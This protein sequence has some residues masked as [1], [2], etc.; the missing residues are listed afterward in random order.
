MPKGWTLVLIFIH[1]FP[2]WRP[3][4]IFCKLFS[5]LMCIYVSRN[6]LHGKFQSRTP[7]KLTVALLYCFRSFPKCVDSP[8]WDNHKCSGNVG[9]LEVVARNYSGCVLMNIPCTKNQ[10][11]KGIKNTNRSLFYVDCYKISLVFLAVINL[12]ISRTGQTL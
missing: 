12:N 4:N 3:V 8:M 11:L 2:S 10:I 1:P 9:N 6:T 5:I 7:R